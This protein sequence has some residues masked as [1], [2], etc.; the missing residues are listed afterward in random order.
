M[1][2]TGL[3]DT[4]VGVMKG[5]KIK[6]LFVFAGTANESCFCVVVVVVLKIKE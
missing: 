4:I 6:C 1:I 2:H 5:E 3:L